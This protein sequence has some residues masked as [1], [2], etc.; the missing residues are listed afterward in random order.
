[1]DVL[2]GLASRFLEQDQDLAFSFAGAAGQFV[3]VGFAAHEAINA[4]FEVVVDLA[5][6]D[7]GI[8]LSALLDKP[9]V[10][11]LHSKYQPIRHLHG[12]V[13]EAERGD[14]GHR[15]TFY[16]LVLRPAFAR[17]DHGADSRI[18]QDQTVPQIAQAVLAEYGITDT[19]WRLEG[20]H[21]PR[22]FLTQYRETHRAFLERILAEEGIF[23]FF[24]HGPSGHR[25]IF[26][27][28][29]LATPEIGH[30]P[31]LGY[32]PRPGGQSRG[33][34]VSHF[35][36]RQRLR[37]SH[38]AMNDYTFHNP[39]ADMKTLAAGQ[40]LRG[41]S[42][43]YEVY[44]F[45]G[46]YKDPGGVG[47]GF[48]RHRIEALRVDATTGQGTTNALHLSPGFQVT[49]KGHDD[50]GANIRHRLLAVSHSGSQPAALEEDAGGGPT[51][52]QA[53][54]VTQPGHLPYRPPL[55]RKP[56]V[57][58][59]QIAIVTGPEGEEIY[60]DE[61]GRVKLW[62][63]WDRRG[64]QNEQSSCW[65]RVSQN[66]AGGTWGHIAIPRIGHEV[67]VEFLE[68]DP[69]QPIITGRTYHANNRTPYPLPEHKTKMVIRSDTH[70]G[71]GFNEIS[72]E[73]E[74]GQEN[75][76][77]HAQKDQT[78]KILHNRMKRV[79]NDQIESVGSNKSIEVGNN[80]QEAI[81][82]SMNLSVGGG[83]IGL[84]AGLAALMG[85][86]A[87]A[88]LNG[89][90]EVGNPFA[91]LFTAGLAAV[92]AAGSVAS[93]PGNASFATAGRNRAIA[94]ADQGVKGTSLGTLLNQVMPIGG[95]MN[96]VVEK[97]KS[98][99]VGIVSTE[100]IGAL[101]NTFVGIVDNTV[102]GKKRMTQIGEVCATNVGRTMTITVGD[103]YVLTVGKSSLILTKEGTI[104]LKGVKIEIEAD[105]H[106]VQ[107]SPLIDLN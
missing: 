5:S 90:N 14:S 106:I 66:W 49:L 15:R 67:V 105:K 16:T 60:T 38:Y 76:A 40:D 6:E 25:M 97:A 30:Q 42:G 20:A 34:W 10:L 94:G 50:A 27:D 79:D 8:D 51:T 81:G 24:E 93:V 45:P 103:E 73:D 17:L 44:D 62:F 59:P 36:Q 56:L 107:R 83:G 80:H 12:I 37:S 46:R 96:I 33:A 69:D 2:S 19:S 82:G 26:T 61:H 57:D 1:M 102:V 104:I 85:S 28:A 32:N 65:I 9:A 18:W 52:Y 3:V 35:A 68:G 92:S 58:G 11:G 47:A 74:A 91:P 23:Y 43:R 72:F 89:A 21:A 95:I 78:L 87:E 99:T 84:I 31:V 88:M 71:T 54:F 48:T 29:P 77:L 22:E 63:P 100:Q 101:K 64:Q 75:I 7:P 86:S 55:A 70:K 4:P 53:S 13:T 98:E 39:P 41:L